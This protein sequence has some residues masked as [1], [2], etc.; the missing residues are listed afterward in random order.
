MKIRVN[1]S[2]DKDAHELSSQIDKNFSHYVENLI[3]IDLKNQRITPMIE[4]VVSVETL[5]EKY[6][7]FRSK[8][9]FR[10]CDTKED[11]EEIK[12]IRREADQVFQSI[13]Q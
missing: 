11:K 2:I 3:L 1:I 4:N 12:R 5:E 10:A 9:P 7:R 8:H 6:K 13:R